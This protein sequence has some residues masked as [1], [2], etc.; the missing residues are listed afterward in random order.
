MWGR[1]CGGGVWVGGASLSPGPVYQA[2]VGRPP[3]RPSCRRTSQTRSHRPRRLSLNAHR[4]LTLRD[5][6]RDRRATT[7]CST[8]DVVIVC[9]GPTTGLAPARIGRGAAAAAVLVSTASRRKAA[10]APRGPVDASHATSTRRSADA[11]APRSDERRAAASAAALAASRPRPRRAATAN[12]ATRASTASASA[13]AAAAAVN[14]GPT[15]STWAATMAA[16]ARSGAVSHPSTPLPRVRAE[17]Q[18]ESSARA[19]PAAG[20]ASAR[21]SARAGAAAE[22]TRAAAPERPAP[23]R[24]ERAASTASSSA[25]ENSGAGA[26]DVSLASSSTNR[27][28]SVSRLARGLD[29]CGQDGTGRGPWG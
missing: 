22:R 27:D 20:G 13:A 14:R 2:R 28:S 12:A 6:R 16:A 4:V 8:V 5:G 17:T 10:P 21:A 24:R 18:A 23:R 9:W 7:G 15:A 25:R 26:A 1:K 3:G 11:V 19:E 29:A